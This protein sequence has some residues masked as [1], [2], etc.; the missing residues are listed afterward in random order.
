VL[1]NSR[2]SNEAYYESLV[3]P[4]LLAHEKSK[5][6]AII[7]SDQGTLREVLKHKSVENVTML[8]VDKGVIEFS[9]KYIFSWTDC[10][11]ITNS[12]PCC[13]D[14]S[15][16]ELVYENAVEWLQKELNHTNFYEKKF[17]VIICDE[18]RDF[19]FS[20]SL[21]QNE[22]LFSLLFQALSN[23]G[24]IIMNLGKS[25]LTG[26]P[27]KN[28]NKATSLL[29][30]IGMESFHPYENFHQGL[31]ELWSYLVGCKNKE[32]RDNWQSNSALIEVA[33]H[34]GLNVL[35]SGK[36]PLRYLDGS[37]MKRFQVPHKVFE[38][39]YCRRDPI[40]KYCKLLSS[41]KNHG[42]VA[43]SSFDV[44]GS[45]IGKNAG[46]GV[47]STKNISKGSLIALEM[48]SNTIR[49]Y[50]DS[51]YIIDT[52]IHVLEKKSELYAV[53]AYMYEYGFSVQF[54]V[55]FVSFR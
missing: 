13:F 20:D 2:L 54:Y 42:N 31:T 28:L 26:M 40:P 46:R 15:H 5:N 48:G 34:E 7:G 10:S 9:C 51:K 39:E 21:Y 1:Q 32:C 43:C 38:R 16:V 37:I 41:Y 19:L 14:N 11:D 52:N 50:P 25:S 27:S 49:I 55:S 24:I 6:I 4:G 29:E 53:F 12:T 35:N 47:F 36:P 22:I 8:K 30:K 23:D 17:D 18:L 45:T 3:H 33:I 44:R